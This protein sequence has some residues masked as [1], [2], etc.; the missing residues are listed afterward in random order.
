MY[1]IHEIL[2]MYFEVVKQNQIIKIIYSIYET[3]STK[4]QTVQTIAYSQYC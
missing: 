2:G 1:T 3:S 4:I